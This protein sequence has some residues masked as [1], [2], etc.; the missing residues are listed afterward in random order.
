[1]RESP[2][3]PSICEPPSYIRIVRPPYK[4]EYLSG[5]PID[6]TGMVVVAYMSSG[7]EWGTISNDRLTIIPSTATG[8]GTQTIAVRYT[9]E[10]GAV[11]TDTFDISV[12]YL[13][14]SIRIDT[15]PTKLSYVDQES[16]DLTGAVV[17]AYD[18]DGN[19]WE[20]TGYSG[21]VIPLNELTISPTKA[22]YVGGGSEQ[23]QTDGAV[24]VGNVTLEDTLYCIP[25]VA[26]PSSI[27]TSSPTAEQRARFQELKDNATFG[28]CWGASSES[29]DGNT[30]SIG[31]ERL[32]DYTTLKDTRVAIAHYRDGNIIIV[33]SL[34]SGVLGVGHENYSSSWDT[35][36]RSYTYDNKT[37]Y[38][39]DNTNITMTSSDVT[40]SNIVVTGG[41]QYAREP[42]VQAIAWASWYMATLA[43]SQDIT[44]SWNRPMDR[45]LLTDTFEIEVSPQ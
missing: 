43:E 14:E 5:E 18:G 17:K 36:A 32:L 41:A 23:Y 25:L 20:D 2:Y 12:I 29:T 6:I 21:G 8:T 35:V 22:T 44:V 39:F 11:L 13:P 9:N 30:W 3:I 45:R 38:F 37:V 1:M 7:I 31:H 24:T 34:D 15:L 40:I 19:I 33:S 16:I 42:K 27:G 4:L 26:A 28:T 10:V